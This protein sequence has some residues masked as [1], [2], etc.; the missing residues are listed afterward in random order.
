MRKALAYS[1]TSLNGAH[2][3]CE[4]SQNARKPSLP[5]LGCLPFDALPL[6][7]LRTWLGRGQCLSSDIVVTIAL[8]GAL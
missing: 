2:Y 7:E 5:L 8:V 1:I 3:A 6:V 4:T